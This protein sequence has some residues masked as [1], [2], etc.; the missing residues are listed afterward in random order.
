M[1]YQQTGSTPQQG[2]QQG[3]GQGQMNQGADEE[4]KWPFKAFEYPPE[5]GV[6]EFPLESREEARRGSSPRAGAR[7]KGR[8]QQMG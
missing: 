2:S 5:I 8:S 4:R 3:G 7:S 1:R 6:N